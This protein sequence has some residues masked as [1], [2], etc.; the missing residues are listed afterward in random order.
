MILYTTGCPKCKVLAMKLDQ[1]NQKYDICDSIETME[2]LGFAEAPMLQLDDG[3][4]YD[5]SEA[6]KYVNSL[7]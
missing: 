4:I 3:T 2:S 6:I 5:F 7:G 1:K